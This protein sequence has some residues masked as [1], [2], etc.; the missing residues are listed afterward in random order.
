MVSP[1]HCWANPPNRC[2][3]SRGN[4][5]YWDSEKDLLEVFAIC[6][7]A[8][9][10]RAGFPSHRTLQW[11]AQSNSCLPNTRSSQTGHIHLHTMFW[12]HQSIVLLPKWKSQ[13]QRTCP[14]GASW[15]FG[16]WGQGT[17]GVWDLQRVLSAFGES[18]QIKSH[19]TVE[20]KS[21][22]TCDVKN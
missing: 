10:V 5:G 17:S 19:H 22:S 21:C 12:C 3:A 13:V 8:N 11:E 16:F 14:Q 15:S 1:R 9:E 2:S 4:G 7:P 20:L 18:S 6:C